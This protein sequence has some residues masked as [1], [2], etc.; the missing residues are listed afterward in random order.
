LVNH[1]G[2]LLPFYQNVSAA[3][4]IESLFEVTEGVAHVVAA[5][6]LERLYEVMGSFCRPIGAQIVALQ[7]P[8]LTNDEK[9]NRKVAGTLPIPLILI[10]DCVE[11]LTIFIQTVTP[12]VEPIQEHPAV[13]LLSELW[14]ALTDTLNIFGSVQYIS[15]SV[16]KCFKNI[17]YAYRIHSL[18]LLGPMAEILVSSFESYEY[19]C[20]L[21]ASGAIVRQFGHEDVE[22]EVR[23]AIWQFVERQC[24]NT[25]R[26]LEKNKPND[27]PDRTP[28]NHFK[29]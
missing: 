22:D 16:A 1:V 29:F 5:Q 14:P 2:Q 9:N 11:L 18:P 27:I 23:F 28:P 26:L 19:G 10:K 20:F 15:E 24:I 21:W 17:I 7:Q 13:H 8:G 6:P 3:L 25:F 12:Y 4:D